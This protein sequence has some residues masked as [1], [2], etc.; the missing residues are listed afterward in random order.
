MTKLP[1]NISLNELAISNI[2]VKANYSLGELNGLI[3][4]LP[5]PN[6]V[7]SIVML[8]ESKNSS[9]IENIITTYDELFSSLINS[10]KENKSI[11]EVIN[12]KSALYKGFELVKE[13]DFIN[14]NIIKQIHF[15]LLKSKSGI[16][17][18]P[19][20]V[21]KNERTG[22]VHHIPPQSFEEI[23][24][25]LENL[26]NYINF[27]NDL[28]P[29]INMA[30]I[31]Y[32]FESIHPFYDGNG[33]TGRILNVLYLVLKEKIDL[34]ILFLSK[35]INKTKDQYYELFK[36][37]NED[38]KNIDKFIIYMLNGINQTAK[39]TTNLVRGINDLM[40]I[41]DKK[42]KEK[43]PDIYNYKIVQQIFCNLYT[44]NKIFREDLN[45]SRNTATKYLKLLEKEGFL[46]SEKVG[47][48]VIYKNVQLFN[49]V[50]EE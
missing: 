19:G 48:E 32:Q 1:Y 5:N 9:A 33:R 6:I 27:E 50:D 11:K 39:Y 17:K 22:D 45:I 21:I 44:K 36:K 15:E 46:I 34:P 10:N 40:L 7:L 26:D 31:H 42:M 37:C 35:Y 25:Y 41:T 16:R 2:L 23:N 18:L 14:T 8:S 43:L 49:I 12:Y 28:D 30:I 24:D 3:K 13:N 38:I 29:L 4:L 20:T 47:K